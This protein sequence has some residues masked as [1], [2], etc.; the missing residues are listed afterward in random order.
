MWKRKQGSPG[1]FAKNF[2]KN[3]EIRCKKAVA[4]HLLV[5]RVPQQPLSDIADADYTADHQERTHLRP[6]AGL[7]VSVDDL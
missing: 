4:G 2:P 6:L 3:M 7:P 5:E 1:N